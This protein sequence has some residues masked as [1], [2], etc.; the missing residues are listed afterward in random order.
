MRMSPRVKRGKKSDLHQM[1]S[2]RAN[3]ECGDD[4]SSGGKVRAHR[5][6]ACR[7][8]RND[9]KIERARRR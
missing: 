2:D 8:I 1:R 4:E 3:R 5:T 6:Q 7:F 9:A